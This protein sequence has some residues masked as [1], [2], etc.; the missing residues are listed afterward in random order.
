MLHLFRALKESAPTLALMAT[1]V[2]FGT[3][4]L[5][6][7]ATKLSNEE[8]ARISYAAAMLPEF[9]DPTLNDLAKPS[10]GQSPRPR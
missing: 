8:I 1:G 6:L 5:A 2:A 3:S 9:G 4:L 7:R 10:T